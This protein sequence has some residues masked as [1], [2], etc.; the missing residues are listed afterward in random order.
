M[1]TYTGLTVTGCPPTSGLGCSVGF[2]APVT[3]S[4]D[5]GLLTALGDSGQNVQF[6]TGFAMS[7]NDDG[8]NPN[9]NGV[10]I[11]TP[12]PASLMLLGSGFLAFVVRRR[13]VK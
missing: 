12:E 2:N 4:L 11:A 6:W 7:L 3:G 9:S 1:G 13:V 5:A 10:L 8:S